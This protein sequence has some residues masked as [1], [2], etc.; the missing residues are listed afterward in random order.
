[1]INFSEVK[2]NDFK[3]LVSFLKFSDDES[4]GFNITQ[5]LQ[6]FIADMKAVQSII[7]N[8][9]VT[10][11]LN[12][13]IENAEILFDSFQ[14]SYPELQFDPEGKLD[15]QKI[16]YFEI[17]LQSCE[18]MFER[19]KYIIENPNEE[20]SKFEKNV[21]QQIYDAKTL[22]P[23][24]ALDGKFEYPMHRT[25]YFKKNPNR[26]ITLEDFKDADKKL[27]GILGKNN[28][29]GKFL[30]YIFEM[31]PERCKFFIDH[32]LTRIDILSKDSELAH[33]ANKDYKELLMKIG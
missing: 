3:E 16:D 5:R 26:P 29:M 27:E 17:K 9:I 32:F 20:I 1:M 12:N 10:D 13:N 25:L 28:I 21:N 15:L 6:R 30:H 8:N 23:L 18:T 2:F 31:K 19:A 24:L 11:I 4:E 33:P 22:N 14:K 7:L